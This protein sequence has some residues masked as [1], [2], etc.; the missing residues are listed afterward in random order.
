MNPISL[1][2]M[3]L[4][5]SSIDLCRRL[6]TP[7]RSKSAPVGVTPF[8]LRVVHRDDRK[9][10]SRDHAGESAPVENTFHRAPVRS[11]VSGQ[12]VLPCLRGRRVI[13]TDDASQV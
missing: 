12:G 11:D 9:K 4:T 1:A 3:S 5:G 13:G 6:H 2:M 7:R 10:L 8:L